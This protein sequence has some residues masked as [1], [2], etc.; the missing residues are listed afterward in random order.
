M[1]KKELVL[2]K[3]SK[4]CRKRYGGFRDSWQDFW[5]RIKVVL[6]SPAT[7]FYPFLIMMLFQDLWIWL[8]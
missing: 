1:N 4:N 8:V 7:F 6:I 3:D 5:K 2:I